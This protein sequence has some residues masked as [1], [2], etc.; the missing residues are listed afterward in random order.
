MNDTNRSSMMVFCRKSDKLTS[1][2]YTNSVNIK[3]YP[4]TLRTLAFAFFLFFFDPAALRSPSLARS[5]LRVLAAAPP[6]RLS[7]QRARCARRSVSPLLRLR[8]RLPSPR[9][10]GAIGFLQLS[11]MVSVSSALAC[12]TRVVSVQWPSLLSLASMHS[13][14]LGFAV[15]LP[16][17]LF[18]K[19]HAGKTAAGTSARA[20]TRC[21]RGIGYSLRSCLFSSAK[22]AVSAS[23]PSLLKNRRARH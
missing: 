13:S 21:T 23:L 14:A 11:C 16:A 17:L 9:S 12:S 4:G 20:L 15:G 19:A 2:N 8:P 7:R 1:M 3:Y 18:R 6:V 22:N 5:G 10:A